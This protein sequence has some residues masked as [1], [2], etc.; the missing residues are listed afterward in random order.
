V[1]TAKLVQQ[2][3]EIEDQVLAEGKIL[4]SKLPGGKSLDYCLGVVWMAD[5][6]RWAKYDRV[7]RALAMAGIPGGDLTRQGGRR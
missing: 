6:D 5:R 1:N 4:R 7:R 3:T 2:Q